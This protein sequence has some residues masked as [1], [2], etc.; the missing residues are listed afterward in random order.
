MKMLL[1]LFH[2]KENRQRPGH[3]FSHSTTGTSRVAPPGIET[4]EIKP[5]DVLE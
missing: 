4:G 2:R 1:E 3:T 5:R